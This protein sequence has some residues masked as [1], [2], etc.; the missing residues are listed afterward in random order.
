M[1]KT[2]VIHLFLLFSLMIPVSAHATCFWWGVGEFFVPGLGYIGTS[3]WDKVAVMGTLRWGSY[4]QYNDA[5]Y[6][7]I[8]SS[9]DTGVVTESEFYQDNSDKIYVTTSEEDSASGK[10]ETDIYLNEE[11]WKANYFLSLYSNLGL[12]SAWDLYQDCEPNNELYSMSL[13]PLKVTRFFDKWYFWAPMALLAYN[14]Q[15]FNENQVVRYHLGRGLTRSDLRNDSFYQYYSVGLGEEMFFRGMLQD[16]FFSVMK[17]SWSW[18]PGFSRHLAVWSA[19]AF[20]GLAHSGTGF[21]AS[22]G[23]AFLMGGYMGYVYHPSLEE[24]DLTTAIALHTWWDIIIAY[25]ILNNATFVETDGAVQ[26]PL[27]SV[28]FK[29]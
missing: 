21:T 2:K 15:N 1:H 11:T 10:L 19:A 20:F 26:I 27:A 29:F 18:S 12:M 7:T 25:T 8:D 3:Q 5:R 24:F 23:A 22:P 9:D 16:Y 13:A 28:A 6:V 4:L 14:A 17:N